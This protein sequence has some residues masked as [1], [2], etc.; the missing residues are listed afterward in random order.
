MVAAETI[1][2]PIKTLAFCTEE[3]PVPY[4]FNKKNEIR[5]NRL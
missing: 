1:L 5:L 3:G 4:F 2:A